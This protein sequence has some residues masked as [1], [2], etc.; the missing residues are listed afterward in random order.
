MKTYM[1]NGCGHEYMYKIAEY[2]S[3]MR[4]RDYSIQ[5]RT[6]CR[7]RPCRTSCQQWL[8]ESMLLVPIQQTVMTQ[9]CEGL[10]L[11]NSIVCR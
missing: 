5:A 2:L 1:M 3:S 9:D 6:L 7:D 4:R 8:V 10:Q 11:S